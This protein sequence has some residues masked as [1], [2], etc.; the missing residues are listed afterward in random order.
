MAI[1]FATEQTGNEKKHVLYHVLEQFSHDN[2]VR[3]EVLV[4]DF[5]KSNLVNKGIVTMNRSQIDN[6]IE[7]DE[8]TAQ[9]II[10]GIWEKIG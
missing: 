3:V 8:D 6:F 4:L 2:I 1:Y 10:I 7:V 9:G 5:V